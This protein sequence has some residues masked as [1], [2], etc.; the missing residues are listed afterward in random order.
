MVSCNH[1]NTSSNRWILDSGATH[2]MT[3]NKE[4]M[5][6]MVEVQDS[7]KINLPTA[8]T[9]GIKGVGKVTL[10]SG[11]E[12]KNVM[13]IPSFKQNLL[14]IHKLTRDSGCRVIIM[15]NSCIIRDENTAAVIG[16][17]RAEKGLYYLENE[18]LKEML[19]RIRES[20]K[21][22]LSEIKGNK[23]CSA[24][25][26][27]AELGVPNSIQATKKLSGGALWHLRLGHA[28]MSRIYKISELQGC[29]NLKE[30]DVCLVCPM[31]RFTKL[32]FA[33]NSGRA[34]M[35]FE[36]IH[37]DIW[38][39]YRVATRGGYKYFLT[40]VDDNSR[41]TW[42]N[43]L[44]L[45]SEAYS[46]IR[47]F[48]HMDENQFEGRV[49]VLRSDNGL[50][51]EDYQCKE[52][53][54]QFGIIHQRTCV[55]T[56]QQNGRA[57]RRHR[58]ILEMARALRFQASLPLC[59][60]GDCVLA[61]VHI[62]NRLPT[63]V[64]GDRSP[65][66]V[67]F[68]QTPSYN[69]L[70]VFGC[71]A[72]AS[73]PSRKKDK[74]KCRG[75]PCVFL[76]YPQHQKGYKL[77]NLITNTMFVSRNVRFHENVFPYKLFRKGDGLRP[78]DDSSKRV[79]ETCWS[80][81]SILESNEGDHVTQIEPVEDELAVNNDTDP[82]DIG[83]DQQ[84]ET[85][86]LTEERNIRRSAREHKK[87]QWHENYVMGHKSEVMSPTKILS[88]AQTQVSCY[89]SSLMSKM[90]NLK[91]PTSFKE[92]VKEKRWVDAMNEEL[93]ALE[94]NQTWTIT[95]LPSGKT[96]IG[97]KWLYKVKYRPDGE[98][99]RYK[100]RLVILGNRQKP[101][102]DYEETFAPVAKLTTVRSLLAIASIQGWS[103][104]Q[105][106][107][108]NA[109]LHG[110]LQE[111]VFMKLPPGYSSIG[112]R[113]EVQ[114]DYDTKQCSTELVCKLNKSL[115]GLKQAPRQWYAKLRHALE[116]Y[117]FHQSKSDS[118]LFIKKTEN[119]ITVVLVYVD[120]LLVAGNSEEV[121]HSTKK[122]L[123]SQFSMKDLG[124]VRYFLGL[125]IDQSDKGIFLSQ[126]KYTH[127]LLDNYGMTNCKPLKLPLD[128]HIKLTENMGTPLSDPQ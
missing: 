32:P 24:M 79:S 36:L 45:K 10:K 38:G 23:E 51:F 12:L 62:T 28:S 3:N 56:P 93:E 113:I 124:G 110:E 13:W 49:K 26:A 55:D 72:L 54:N 61:A 98:I 120:D 58:S 11:I 111:T 42:V 64:L 48:V 52:L 86:T 118:S 50:E 91:E 20:A 114:S 41:V 122:F 29:K 57:E 87:P 16:V 4:M 73:N 22:R 37:V 69:H 14:S 53:Y 121:I 83:D 127:D 77:L 94:K 88:V 7:P 9:S 60:W 59:F 126:S 103:M 19:G 25:T 39:P 63:S 65:Y 21:G 92:A 128:S 43:L 125:E 123:T 78:D 68:K 44:R 15:E 106:D 115:Y 30:H 119:S 95:H 104:H 75:V 100:S 27:E 107:V 80:G 34:K 47:N 40:V 109:F 96:P 67:L 70:K 76:G 101:G 74:F 116:E 35:P 97:C 5:E 105:M 66:E 33:L 6:E 17:G 102:I 84:P 2:H 82:N 108:K 81:E 1:V 8:E 46:V 71:L 31:A 85:E 99:E 90:K 18:T 117:D 89:F 112:D